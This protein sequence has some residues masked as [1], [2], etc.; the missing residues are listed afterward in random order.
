MSNRSGQLLQL[1]D[2][3][4]GMAYTADQAAAP[5]GK[6]VIRLV[7]ERFKPIISETT[8]K[9]AFVFLKPSEVRGIGMFD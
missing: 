7:D 4:Y 3:S 6:L 2:G 9:Q 8:G 1:P 5:A